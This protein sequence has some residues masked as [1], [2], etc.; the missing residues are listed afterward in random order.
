MGVRR[1]TVSEAHNTPRR[2]TWDIARR[3]GLNRGL[4]GVSRRPH[5]R[6]E[7][8][9]ARATDAKMTTSGY[10]D[11]S[12]DREGGARAGGHAK[13]VEEAGEAGQE[14]REEEEGQR[15]EYD[16]QAVAARSDGRGDEEA[17]MADQDEGGEGEQG[18]GQDDGNVSGGAASGE[19]GDRRSSQVVGVS[20]H[21]AYGKWGA[22]R[23]VNGKTISL[24]F[25][26]T[27]EAADRVVHKY[28]EAGSY[29]RPLLSST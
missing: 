20:W 29:T 25:Y 19:A 28:M 10:H 23:R 24:G 18:E 6:H 12:S 16:D 27:Q 22:R 4:G 17:E 21:K 2:P 11:G 3:G 5:H 1:T 13:Q 15:R 8:G 9:A 7:P 14:A 26:E